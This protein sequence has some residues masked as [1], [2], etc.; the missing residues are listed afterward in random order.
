[1]GLRLSLTL[2]VK[3]LIS[4]LRSFAIATFSAKRNKDRYQTSLNHSE[5][6]SKY[7]HQKLFIM[8]YMVKIKR[9]DSA[10][11]LGNRKTPDLIAH[12]QLKRSKAER[13]ILSELTEWVT[14]TQPGLELT[15]SCFLW[16]IF[17]FVKLNSQTL[18]CSAT[19]KLQKE[20]DDLIVFWLKRKAISQSTQTHAA[21][22][23]V[24]VA[25]YLLR[26][27]CYL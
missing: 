9:I 27:T 11:R 13:Q 25:L 4:L 22:D 5:Q 19:Q 14:D 21:S 20:R 15:Y 24:V 23:T 1:M 17:F 12:E 8:N 16:T 26:K 2:E 3:F 10:E 6:T 18:S 7:K